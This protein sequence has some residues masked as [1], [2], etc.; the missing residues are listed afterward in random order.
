MSG[1]QEDTETAAVALAAALDREDYAAA[2]PL[3]DDA[4]VYQIRGVVIDGADAIISSYRTNGEA[5]RK[6]FDSV[7]YQSSVSTLADGRA[8]IDCTDIVTHLGNTLIHRCA[9]EVEFDHAGK[10]TRI[11]HID[12]DGEREALEEFKASHP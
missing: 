3:L 5:G 7:R 4:C 12:F 8:R 11:T 10:A 6:R 9:Q 1:F 2:R